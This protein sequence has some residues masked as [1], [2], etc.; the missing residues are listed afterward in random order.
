MPVPGFAGFAGGDAELFF[1]A[2]EGRAGEAGGLALGF[3]LFGGY[4][5]GSEEVFEEGGGAV[6][7]GQAGRRWW[8]RLRRR[9]EVEAVGAD[10]DADGIREGGQVVFDDGQAQVAGVIHVGDG[11]LPNDAG[12]LNDDR[13]ATNAVGR[14]LALAVVDSQ[15]AQ[16]MDQE[17]GFLNVAGQPGK[18]GD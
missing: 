8:W 4:G 18:V 9:A 17:D 12:K 1:G 5:A 3:D 15:L 11:Q 14:G 6:L 7:L 10:P 13:G 16:V 2:V